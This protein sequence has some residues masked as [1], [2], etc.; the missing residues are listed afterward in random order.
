MDFLEQAQELFQ[1]DLEEDLLDFLDRSVYLG[2]L[3]VVL[4]QVRVDFLELM[5]EP[6]LLKEA[7]WEVLLAP[8]VL[9]IP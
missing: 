1:V 5:V 8:L 9:L 7:P 6:V 4:E 2:L 3:Q